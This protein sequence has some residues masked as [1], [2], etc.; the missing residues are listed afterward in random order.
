MDKNFWSDEKCN[1]CGI[2]QNICPVCNA[3]NKPLYYC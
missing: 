3:S 2:C 1:K